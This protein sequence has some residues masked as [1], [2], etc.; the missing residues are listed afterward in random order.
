MTSYRLKPL[1]E[2]SLLSALTVI[3]ALAAVYLPVVGMAAALVWA[4]PIIV[5][6]VR[7]GLRWGIMAVLVSGIIMAL[8][9]EPM[10]S[11][12]MVSIS[13]TRVW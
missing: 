3:L 6:V 10:I 5:L 11:L 9:I 8:L 2:S 13:S 12:R 1:T 4:L 7:H